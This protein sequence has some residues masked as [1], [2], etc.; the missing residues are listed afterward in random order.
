MAKKAILGIGKIS[1]NVPE[2]KEAGLQAL[3]TLL[4]IEEE[5]HIIASAIIALRGK[6]RDLYSSQC[7]VDILRKYPS[8]IKE[9]AIELSLSLLQ[10]KE[11]ESRVFFYCFCL[12]LL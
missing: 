11:I 2:A 9:A 10:I 4:E 7:V 6:S 3:G 1:C 8:I 5:H 12:F